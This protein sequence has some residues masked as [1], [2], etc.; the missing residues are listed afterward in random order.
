MSN[1]KQLFT[2]F[3]GKLASRQEC[4][5]NEPV[6]NLAICSSGHV[7]KNLGTSLPK[8]PVA[9]DDK[10]VQKMDATLSPC[11]TNWGHP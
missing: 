8:S 7:E 9:L 3:A 10:F 1:F 2:S 5:I 6:R 4:A 11:V